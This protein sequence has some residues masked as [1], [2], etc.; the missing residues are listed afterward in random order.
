MSSAEGGAVSCN[1]EVTYTLATYSQ[2]QVNSFLERSGRAYSLFVVL[3]SRGAYASRITL[4]GS[5]ILPVSPEIKA[6]FS[7][8]DDIYEE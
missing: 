5:V 4:C 3:S 7:S 6:L 1:W 2:W 8:A